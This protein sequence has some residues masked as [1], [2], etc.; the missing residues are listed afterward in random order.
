[1]GRLSI[2]PLTYPAGLRKVLT[3]LFS[4]VSHFV[5]F[6]YTSCNM[7]LPKSAYSLMIVLASKGSCMS[8]LLTLLFVCHDGEDCSHLLTPP[9]TASDRLL[10]RHCS[11]DAELLLSGGPVDAIILH[12]DHFQLCSSLV[13]KLRSLAPRTPV[14]LLRTGRN[15]GNKIKPPGIVAVCSADLRDKNL[16]RSLWAFFRLVLGKQA[17][18][19][20]SCAQAQMLLKECS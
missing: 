13:A 17:W 20:C 10:V 14:L 1:M 16:V 7:S 19:V 2:Y 3:S 11:E 9:P 8:A 18:K 15:Q 4:L 6:G 5:P 12:Q